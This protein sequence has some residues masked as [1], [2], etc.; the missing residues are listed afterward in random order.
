MIHLKDIFPTVRLFLKWFFIPYGVTKVHPAMALRYLPGIPPGAAEPI[1]ESKLTRFLKEQE[2]QV[3][4]CKCW[5]RNKK[6]PP[7]CTTWPCYFQYY[8]KE[9]KNGKQS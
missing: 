8:S 4:G 3:C 5:A 2:C 1:I 7:I 9:N 6:A